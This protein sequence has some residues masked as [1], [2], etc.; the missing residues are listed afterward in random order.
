MSLLVRGIGELVTNDP[1]LGDGSPLGLIT[2]AALVID[3]GRVAWV[4]PAAAA[5][6]PPTACSTPRRRGHPG[7]RRQP[8]P[9]GLRRRPR[10]RVRR[11]DGRR[12]LHRRRHP[13]DRRR[14]P[15]RL[16]RATCARTVARLLAE[17]RGRAPPPSRSRAGTGC[18]PWTKPGRCAWPPSSPTR[19]RSSARTWCRPEF[20]GP[21]G[22]LRRPGLRR[23]ARRRRA[24]RPVGGRVLR[25]GRVRRRPGPGGPDRRHRGRAAAPRLH[26]NQ[27]QPGPGVQLAVELGRGQRRPLHP[28]DPTPTWTRWPARRPWP[29]CCPGPSSPPARRTR[30]RAGC[31]T[32]GSPW[33]WP[34]TATPAPRTRPRCPSA[35]R[36]PSGRCG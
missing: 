10:G 36:W 6:R 16:R 27:L 28:P 24:V 26:A 22:R 2:D 35:S 14:H 4:G 25:P 18:P 11:P 15:G 5:P 1:T 30:T 19:P 12:A 23:D 7:L 33:R 9:P 34:P 8:R 32:P 29:P 20:D 13:H 17:A 21:A 31:S 3:D